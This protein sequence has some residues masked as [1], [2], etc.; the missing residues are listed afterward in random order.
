MVENP[1]A[2]Q[3]TWVQPLGLEGALENGMATLS[4]ILVFLPGESHGQR[5]LAGY[6]PWGRNSQTRLSNSYF[7]SFHYTE[8]RGGQPEREEGSEK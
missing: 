6:G 3:E 7:I 5:S 2:V 4:I 8:R 1:P